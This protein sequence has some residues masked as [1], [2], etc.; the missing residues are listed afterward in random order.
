[1]RLSFN[2]AEEPRRRL[3]AA[4]EPCTEARLVRAI[5]RRLPAEFEQVRESSLF[6][7]NQSLI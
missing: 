1:V 5:S 4:G 2:R 3:Q 6:N 7:S